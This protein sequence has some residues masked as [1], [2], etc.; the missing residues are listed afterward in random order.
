MYKLLKI[1]VITFFLLFSLVARGQDKLNFKGQLSAY[2]HLN[3]VNELHWYNGLRYIPQLNYQYGLSDK[4]RI[5]F[6]AS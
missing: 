1:P 3:P 4:H 6:E 5:G 2:T